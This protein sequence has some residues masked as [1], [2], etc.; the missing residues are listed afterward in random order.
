MARS[1]QLGQAH[2]LS[3]AQDSSR[4]SSSPRLLT[5]RPKLECPM[6]LD[7]AVAMDTDAASYMRLV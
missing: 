3:A 7:L 5:V 2:I 6:L 4:F 1:K